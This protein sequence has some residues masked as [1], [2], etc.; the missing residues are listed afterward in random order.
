MPGFAIV[1]NGIDVV[2]SRHYGGQP[3]SESA[4]ELQLE[5]SDAEHCRKAPNV[6]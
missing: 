2:R 1:I 4:G 6:P 3:A 5:V